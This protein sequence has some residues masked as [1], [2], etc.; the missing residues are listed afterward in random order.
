MRQS[1]LRHH[2]RL[3]TRNGSR[4]PNPVT[5][6][7]KAKWKGRADRQSAHALGQDQPAIR[8]YCTARHA[9]ESVS[10]DPCSAKD[11][12]PTSRDT[13]TEGKFGGSGSATTSNLI[14]SS[15]LTISL[16]PG[17]DGSIAAVEDGQLLWCLESEKDSHYRYSPM[18]PSTIID[19]ARRLDR[20][21]DVVAL[22]GWSKTR[23]RGN[24]GSGYL[25]IDPGQTSDATFFGK[26]VKFFTSSHERSHVMM[27]AGMAPPSASEFSTVLVWEGVVGAFYVLNREWDIVRKVPVMQNPGGRYAFL[28]ALVDPTFPDQ[29]SRP[30]PDGSGKLMALAAFEDGTMASPEIARAVDQIMEVNLYNLALKESFS[31][32][33]LHN[34]GID[35]VEAKLAASL[36]SHRIFQRFLKVAR[37]ELPEGTPLSISGGCGLNCDWNSAW[38]HSGH[39]QSVFVP[40]CANDSGSA[41]G[42]AIDAEA[43]LTGPFSL[44]WNVYAG[45]RFEH[46]CV[47]H[48]SQWRGRPFSAP[49]IANVL[50]SGSVVAF[51]QGRWEIGPRALGNRSLLCEPYTRESRDRLNRIKQRED[52]RP[53]APCCR[54]EDLSIAFHETFSDPHMLYFRRVRSSRLQAVTHVD[55]SARVQSVS[56]SSNTRLHELLSAFKAETGMGVLCNT[57]LNRHGCGF[58]NRMTDLVD[59]CEEKG[60]DHFVVDDMWYTRLPR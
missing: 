31:G 22:G 42:T 25:G 43:S 37:Q 15:M 55:G 51:V 7:G 30:R 27:A 32:T 38:M 17:H 44:R 40:P 16:K 33:V 45:D 14:A 5:K 39:F 58:I 26:D 34:A 10:A 21:P 60:I 23:E 29:G 4:P 28:Y 19:I 8:P 41:I 56:E 54:E 13:T 24:V 18:T 2:Q 46:D 36:L 48:P 9:P 1:L 35:S 20:I 47:P 52:F 11:R 49:D 53:I 12:C 6:R 50:S 59:F 3:T 57:S